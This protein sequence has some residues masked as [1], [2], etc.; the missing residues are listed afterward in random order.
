MLKSNKKEKVIQYI[1][2]LFSKCEDNILESQSP[3]KSKAAMETS[4]N[5]SSQ[6][7]ETRPH[8][9]LASHTRQPTSSGHNSKALPA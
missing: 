7:A 9:K 1:K 2:P 3:N 8:N 6:E 4:C 5:P